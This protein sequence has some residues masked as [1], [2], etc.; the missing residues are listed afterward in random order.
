LSFVA[1]LCLSGGFLR[2]SCYFSYVIR[3]QFVH[4]T[5]FSFLLPFFDFCCILDSL[6]PV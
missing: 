3:L 6:F 2:V 4:A 1:F 5:S